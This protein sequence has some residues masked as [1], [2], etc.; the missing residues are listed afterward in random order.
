MKLQ[1]YIRP[2]TDRQ[3]EI[4][5]YI[6][7]YIKDKHYSPAMKDIAEHFGMFT[8]AARDHLLALR[9]KGYI[10]WQEGA[11]RTIRILKKGA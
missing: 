1:R 11:S 8:G 6:D 5:S 9:S 3:K 7:A 2:I 10:D 4:L